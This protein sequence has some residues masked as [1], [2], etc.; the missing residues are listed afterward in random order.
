[1]G[2]LDDA[3]TYLK[4]LNAQQHL[5]TLTQKG[6]WTGRNEMTRDIFKSLRQY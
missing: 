6:V 4:T 5:F 1:M 2:D 3:R